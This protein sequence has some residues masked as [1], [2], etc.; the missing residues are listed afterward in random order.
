MVGIFFYILTKHTECTWF[1]LGLPWILENGS[2]HLYYNF[3][4]IVYTFKFYWNCYIV[5]NILHIIC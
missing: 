3:I 2:I 5:W 4:H 1:S